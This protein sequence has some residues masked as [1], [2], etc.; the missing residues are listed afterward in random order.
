MCSNIL[1][2]PVEQNVH[3]H[4][5]P[6]EKRIHQEWGIVRWKLWE[7]ENYGGAS[8]FQR[9]NSGNKYQMNLTRPDLKNQLW[10]Q[11]IKTIKWES[12]IGT[13]FLW[14]GWMNKIN[15][16]W[17]DSYCEKIYTVNQLAKKSGSY[18]WDFMISESQKTPN[19]TIF[20][21]NR[22]HQP[23]GPITKKGAKNVFCGVFTAIP[24]T[25]PSHPN[26]N[27]PRADFHPPLPP[28]VLTT[29][30]LHFCLSPPLVNWTALFRG[31][32][33]DWNPRHIMT[34]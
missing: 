11:L 23:M 14:S 2:R 22:K 7:L 27:N 3:K 17:H 18:L 21:G 4:T 31:W 30:P 16:N 19:K 32:M 29:F 8:R 26:E 15:I 9:A 20:E 6:W 34:S 24:T 5:I 13:I 28:S 25:I 10:N 1:K 33:S 12:N